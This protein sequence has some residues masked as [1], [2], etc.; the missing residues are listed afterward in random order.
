MGDLV[1]AATSM[2]QRNTPS[3]T[4]AR[5][6]L[7]NA[8]CRTMAANRSRSRSA[9]STSATC[10]TRVT[11]TTGTSTA[12]REAP[13]RSFGWF[14]HTAE[15]PATRSGTLVP[16]T[17]DVR[18]VTMHSRV[19]VGSPRHAGPASRPPTGN[20][21][22]PSS[23]LPVGTPLTTTRHAPS[24]HPG[25][26]RGPDAPRPPIDRPVLVL[27]CAD[28]VVHLRRLY[29]P[30]RR[31]TRPGHRRV[32]G[33]RTRRAGRGETCAAVVVRR[34]VRHLC[35]DGCACPTDSSCGRRPDIQ[36]PSASMVSGSAS[37]GGIS[38]RCP[39]EVA[40][41]REVRLDLGS[42]PLVEGQSMAPR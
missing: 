21:D 6:R 35:L 37:C 2:G 17:M 23:G 33:R 12:E 4:D 30:Q 27:P 36:H 42:A 26:T 3:R 31:L 10:L 20:P 8:R 1:E 19:D 5:R 7:R 39:S 22:A 13:G 28:R 18:R 11:L 25:A 40:P 34:A 14:A 9:T 16:G 24:L 32:P 38:Q 41:A 15:R 29:V